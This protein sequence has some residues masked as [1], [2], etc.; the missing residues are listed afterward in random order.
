[1]M[2]GESRGFGGGGGWVDGWV[3]DQALIII[4]GPMICFLQHLEE[5]G[6]HLNEYQINTLKSLQRILDCHVGFR[7]RNKLNAKKNNTIKNNLNSNEASEIFFFLFLIFCMC[8]VD[9]EQRNSLG[10]HFSH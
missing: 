1:M 8:L 3:G 4:K 5:H 10:V 9:R 2:H 6:S 7:Q